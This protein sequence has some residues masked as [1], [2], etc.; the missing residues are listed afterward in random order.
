MGL[1]KHPPVIPPCPTGLFLEIAPG[2]TLYKIA[3]EQG[4]TVEAILA[5]NP[6]LDPKNLQIGTFICLPLPKEPSRKT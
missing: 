2:D 1:D 6:G 3:K 5:L 4:V